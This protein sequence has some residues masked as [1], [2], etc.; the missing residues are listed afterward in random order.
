MSS[1]AVVIVIVVI[2]SA[3]MRLVFL[4]QQ[5]VAVLHRQCS[6]GGCLAVYRSGPNDLEGKVF[7]EVQTVVATQCRSTPEFHCCRSTNQKINEKVSQVR[8]GV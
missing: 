1:F 4:F 6:C 3:A 7:N 8:D 5:I 2:V